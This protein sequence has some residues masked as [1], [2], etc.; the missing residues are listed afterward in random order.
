MYVNHINVD[1]MY[2]KSTSIYNY[3]TS[4]LQ[5]YIAFSLDLLSV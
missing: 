2:T 1:R 4:K 5:G 3:L